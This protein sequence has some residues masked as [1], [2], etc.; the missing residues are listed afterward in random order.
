MTHTT[1]ETLQEAGLHFGYVRTRRHPTVASFLFGTKDRTDFFDLAQT[2]S[3]LEAAKEFVSA[4]SGSGKKLLFVGGK[5]EC[6]QVIR[7]TAERSGAPYVAS[8]WIGGTLTNFKNI[9]KRIDRLEKLIADTE[10]GAL[11]EKYTKREQ[12]LLSRE[13]DRLTFRF[14]GIVSLQELPGALFVVDPRHEHTAMREANQL[15]IPVIA[16]ASSDC[17]FSQV[18]FP[19]PGNDTTGKSVRFVIDEIADAYATGRRAPTATQ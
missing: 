3:R 1:I 2:A 12:L 11:E 6:A 4:L 9:R 13:I 16:L 10:S 14:G 15:K 5:N 7:E 19:I 8:R 18:Q 17:D